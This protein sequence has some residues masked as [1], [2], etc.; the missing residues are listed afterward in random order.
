MA[1]FATQNNGLVHLLFGNYV[2]AGIPLY[3]VVISAV[4]LGVF[5]SWLVNI[6]GSL[7]SLVTMQ[8]KDATIRDEEKAIR[9]LKKKNEE[10]SLE[11]AHLK[12]EKHGEEQ[13][14]DVTRPS[15]LAKIKGG[16]HKTTYA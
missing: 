12:G 5:V 14:P 15:L 4:L 13:H 1:Y 3:V 6:G 8:N 9:E 10:L 11:L 16:L 2:I 7:S